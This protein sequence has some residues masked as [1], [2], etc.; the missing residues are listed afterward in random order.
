M[1]PASKLKGV[2]DL[3]LNWVKELQNKDRIKA[4]K[5]DTKYNVADILTKPLDSATR[6]KLMLI[7]DNL[8]ENV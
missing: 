1:N 8:R 5:V 4:I 6:N 2:F 3:R 7:V